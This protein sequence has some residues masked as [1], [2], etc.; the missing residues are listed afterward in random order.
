M[1]HYDDLTAINTEPLIVV[2]FWLLL[3]QFSLGC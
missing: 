1:C 3:G 2:K